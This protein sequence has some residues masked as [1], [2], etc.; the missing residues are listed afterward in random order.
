MISITNKTNCCG[1]NA[2]GDA[3]PV[4]A[5]TFK[6][7]NEGFWYPD[8]DAGKCIGCGLCEKVCP[9]DNVEGLKKNDYVQPICYA[10]ENK[11]LEVVFD[12]TSGGAFSALA[13][14]MYRDGGYV[15]GAVY[16][17][18]FYVEHFISNDKKDLPRLRSSKY[19]QS[20]VEGFYKQ[21]KQLLDVGE[22]VLVCGTP[23]QMA[24][25]RAFLGKD[26][27]NLIIVDF[28]CRG[29]N[30]PKVWRK[31]LDSFEERYGS[32]V[33]YCKF[34]SKEFGWRNLTFK[35]V[36]DNGKAYYETKSQSNFTKGYLQTGVYCR[37]SCYECKFKGYPRMA[38]ITLADFWGIEKVDKS[39]EKDLGTSLLMINSKKGEAFLEG[40][41]QRLN[42]IP[43]Q[44]EKAE[45]GNPALN[46]PLAAPKVDRA[47]FFEDLDKMSFTQV[48]GKY[49]AKKT[50]RKSKMKKRYYMLRDV[51][52]L[53]KGNPRSLIQFLKYNTL[54]EILQGNV[55]VPTPHCVLQISKKA[56][57]VKH[58]M[59]VLG[60]KW[61]VK[62]SRIETRL[63]VGDNATLELGDGTVIGYG[64]DIEVFDNA[65]LVFGGKNASNIGMTIICG[66]RIEIGRHAIMG[67]NVT[68]RDN[69]GSHY[70]NLPGYKDSR[71][72]MIGEKVWLCEQS[73]IMPGVKIGD[74]SVIG[75][76]SFVTGN[77][78]AHALVS[79]N[80]AQVM[81]ENVIWK[82]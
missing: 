18:D 41:R 30:S 42:L 4:G 61:K 43:V 21:V 68:I 8:V 70:L 19:L 11:N 9:I 22:K 34:K 40:A 53:T 29:I 17:E 48:A 13:E 5:I 80:P 63:F 38:D 23:C 49:I 1:C 16:T 58:G 47:R 64:A 45:A 52:I 39:M 32:K 57:I 46:K 73:T 75:A 28:V 25:L 10:A 77:V 51:L 71:P 26:Y 54:K 82:S 24:A 20:S 14:K 67:R 2:C 65:T 62:K 81:D 74:G 27:E 59:T 78:P 36:L 56:H 79:G 66:D 31:Y 72:V 44:F 3:C 37:P 15:G 12:S 35:A 60:E 76:L 50:S 7:D 69:N 55:I 6:T 33:A